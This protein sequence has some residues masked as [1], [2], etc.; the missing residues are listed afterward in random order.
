MNENYIESKLTA[1]CREKGVFTSKVNSVARRGFP[2]RI[3][4]HKGKHVFIELKKIGGKPTA[5][6][7]HTHEQ[8]KAAGAD[9]RIAYGWLE[10]KAIIDS[11]L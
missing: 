9:V 5:L 8:M 10:T 7:L 11:L 1:Y 6:Q 2:D 4:I 3:V